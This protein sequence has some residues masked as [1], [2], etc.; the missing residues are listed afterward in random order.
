MK[1][2]ALAL[3]FYLSFNACSAAVYH[4]DY[5]N[6]SDDKDGLS[7]KS[8]FKHCPGDKNATSKA[9]AVSLAPGDTILF[10]GGVVYRGAIEIN[11]SGGE[12]KPIVIDGN[13]AGKYGK[14]MAHL[15]G[16][17]PVLNWKRCKNKAEAAGHPAYKKIWRA[18]LPPGVTTWTAGLLQ[19][20]QSL[21]VAQYP[22]PSDYDFNDNNGEFV[23]TS[24]NQL[25]STSLTHPLLKELGAEHL[26]G[27][28]MQAHVSTNR[29]EIRQVQKWDGSNG[30]IHFKA[31]KNKPYKNKGSFA[32]MN[33]AHPKIFDKPGEY[34][35]LESEK[36][37]AG[38][39]VLL[40][41][42]DGKDPNKSEVTVM[43]ENVA[44]HLKRGNS[45][46][47]VR[48]LQISNYRTA[49]TNY[50]NFVNG[51]RH[52]NNKNDTMRRIVIEDCLVER[53]RDR[54]YGFTVYM[55]A[56]EDCVARRNVIRNT[57]KQ[58]GFGFHTIKN[59]QFL[60]NTLDTVGR[61]PLIMYIAQDCLIKGNTI[62]NCT[63]SHS[64]GISVYVDS[65][66]ITLED[67][68]VWNSK[69]CFTCNE[70]VNVTVRNNV[71]DGRQ[72]G[73]QPMAFWTKVNGQ[74]LIENNIL[75]SGG[76]HH[77]GFTIGGLGDKGKGFKN[78][79]ADVRGNIMSGPMKNVMTGKV[80]G[81]EQHSHGKNIYLKTPDGF[82][83]GE[84]ERVEADLNKLV[85]G[86]EDYSYKRIAK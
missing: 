9:A 75:L 59:C 70:T 84:G 40:M 41:S 57:F 61:T 25:Q 31:F 60:D 48:G 36:T 85:S 51:F 34:V 28:Y 46:I 22:T 66:N 43:R 10:K 62:S 8:A 7:A 63:G 14:G 21:S 56:L 17:L 35:V 30:S 1:Y 4:I 19:N 49:I 45:D 67:N 69:V 78:L 24:G 26:V 64:N 6:G 13:S 47:T 32:V 11:A 23:K 71:F 16:S 29:V 80:I 37:D 12:G 73:T 2:L 27:A 79:K 44:L 42:L 5:D 52:W 20:G 54:N 50:E 38:T 74:V 83:L 3:L 58:R 53:I 82:T 76:N 86:L 18:V 55:I 81:P 72:S 33:L 68:V 39:P 65:K 77:S 15:N